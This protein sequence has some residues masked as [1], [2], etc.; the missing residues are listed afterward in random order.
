MTFIIDKLAEPELLKRLDKI[1]RNP[2]TVGW[3]TVRDH[4]VEARDE[5]ERL[6]ADV[7]EG[8]K[9]LTT[10]L[11]L[12]DQARQESARLRAAL[13]PFASMAA[14]VSEFHPGWDHDAFNWLLWSSEADRMSLEM[15]DLRRAKAAFEHSSGDSDG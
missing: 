13:K 2:R 11:G 3:Q 5:I 15:S 6:R 9:L 8:S 12:L 1:G 10:A 4:A 7:A 14:H